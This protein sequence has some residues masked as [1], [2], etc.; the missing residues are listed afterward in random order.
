MTD[1]NTPATHAQDPQNAGGSA[2]GV[3]AK[4]VVDGV[5]VVDPAIIRRAVGAAAVGNVTEWFDFGVFGYM[6]G[7]I[8]KVFYPGSSP[9]AQLL[10]AFATF[11]AAFLVRPLG[12]LFF[13]PLGDRIGRTKVLAVTMIMMAIGTFCIS[14]IP[15]YDTIG[16]AAPVM[17]LLARLVQGFSTGGEYAG[18]STFIAEYAS[19]RKRGFM[20]SWL[21]FGTLTGY[22]MGAG[23]VTFLSSTLSEHDLLSWGWRIPFLVAGPLGIVGLYLRMKLEETP[24]FAQL[25]KESE[26]RESNSGG[27]F[28]SIFVK[29]W[30][31]MLLC[32]GLV[33]VFNVTNYMLTSYMPTFIT[34]TLPEHHR[35][36]GVSETTSY[37]MQ[38]AVMLVMMLAITFIGRLSDRVGRK[39]VVL[40]GCVALVVLS[41]PAVMLVIKDTPVSLFAGLLIMGL[42]LV[43]FS[44]TMPSTLPALFPTN[45]RYGGLSIA[46]NV[47]VS[48]FGGTTAT[49]MTA[50]VGGTGDLMWPAYYLMAA[51]VIGGIAMYFSKESAGKPLPGSGPSASSESEARELAAAAR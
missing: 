28:R 35:G 11:A 9:T 7:T 40:T 42:Q 13:G 21:E 18:A 46:F 41:I 25:A 15:G 45:I 6:A 23:I 30:P 1:T 31:A 12:G 38:I 22:S 2:A 29:H 33:L 51:G 36:G 32:V 34:E 24:A 43:V 17:L 3:E 49:V 27:E 10:A 44:G 50:L 48:L 47:S 5:T 19:D 39:P 37:I 20:G 8:G 14:I 4:Q 16:L 26:G